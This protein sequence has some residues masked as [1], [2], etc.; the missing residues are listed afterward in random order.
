MKIILNNAYI[1]CLHILY[2]HISIISIQSI[3]DYAMSIYT[4]LT[5]G[6]K[7]WTPKFVSELNQE[8]CL[9]C[10]RCFKAC[11]QDVLNLVGVTEDGDIVDAFD[12]EAEKKIM[13]IIDAD[14]CIGCQAC[15]RACPKN[16]YDFEAV[17]L[18]G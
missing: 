9:G 14:N 12:D 1:F 7:T 6:G 4:A 16:L 17:P 2:A 5:K 11:G 18:A 3:K 10:G 15:N 8:D 13:N